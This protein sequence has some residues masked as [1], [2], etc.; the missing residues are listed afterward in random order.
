MKLCTYCHFNYSARTHI[1]TLRSLELSRTLRH[2]CLEYNPIVMKSITGLLY[3]SLQRLSHIH[4]S[5]INKTLIMF[6]HIVII[7]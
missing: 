2:V 1:L 5:I 6:S 4:D 3:R 7:L